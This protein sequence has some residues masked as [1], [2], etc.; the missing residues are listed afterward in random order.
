MAADATDF[1]LSEYESLRKEIS[2]AVAETRT[3]ERYG[4]TGT[5]AVWTWLLIQKT[6]Q[7]WHTALKW[8]PFM[9]CI[10]LALRSAALLMD[11]IDHAKYIITVEMRYGNKEAFGWEHF[12]QKRNWYLAATGLVIWSALI[13]GNYVFA[14]CFSASWLGAVTPG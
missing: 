5:A 9:F 8:V 14:H 10:I 13:V 6:P 2:E 4:V 12:I 11:I 1:A 7:D 3:L